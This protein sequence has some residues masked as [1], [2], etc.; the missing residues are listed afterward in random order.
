LPDPA[1]LTVV[2]LNAENTPTTGIAEGM[3]LTIEPV[4]N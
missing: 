4:G 3:S 2:A 1:R